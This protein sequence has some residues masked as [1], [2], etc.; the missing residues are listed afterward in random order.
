MVIENPDTDDLVSY[1]ESQIRDGKNTKFVG[2]SLLT[3]NPKISVNLNVNES[4]AL[5]V[6][7]RFW[8]RARMYS[9]ANDRRRSHYSYMA[10][11]RYECAA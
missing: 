8:R 9:Y 5:L 4:K 2:Y 6:Y 7:W 11:L 3:K 10:N 1:L